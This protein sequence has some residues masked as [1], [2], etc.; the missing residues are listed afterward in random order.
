[1]SRG[2]FG[3][4][5]VGALSLKGKAEPVRAWRL[6]ADSEV[7]ARRLTGS[8]VGR[9]PERALIEELVGTVAGGE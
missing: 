5:E 8:L 9:E 4:E 6:V 1:M 2:S 3:F 7:E